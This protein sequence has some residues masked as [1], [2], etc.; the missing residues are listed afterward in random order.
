MSVLISP[1]CYVTANYVAYCILDY[2][3]CVDVH[4]YRTSVYIVLQQKPF[5]LLCRK[6]LM[7]VCVLRLQAF[8]PFLSAEKLLRSGKNPPFLKQDFFTHLDM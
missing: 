6:V 4:T 5:C 1:A 3:L 7:S 8:W 2:N